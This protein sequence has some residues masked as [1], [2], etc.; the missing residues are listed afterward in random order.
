MSRK[1]I[2]FA[3]TPE[4]ACPSL[5]ALI[6]ANYDIVAVY[7][8]P[9]RPAG[10]QR[11]L[12]PP[13]VKVLA[14]QHGLLVRQPN[15]LR[16]TDTQQDLFA[17]SADV[18]VVAAYGQLL[19]QVV[20]DAPKLGCINVH[21]SL[22][23]RWR[24]AS[25]IQQAILAG[26]TETGITIMQMVLALDAGDGYQQVRCPIHQ[27]DTSASVHDRLAHLG[28]KALCEVIEQLPMAGQAQDESQVTYAHKIKKADAICDWR[29]SA[30]QI[31]REIRAFQPWPVATLD[32]QETRY[33]I[34]KADVCTQTCDAAAGT[35]LAWD[36]NGL[37]IACGDGS[38]RITEI[39]APGKRRQRVADIAPSAVNRF[40]VGTQL[41]LP[42]HP[43]APDTM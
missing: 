14:E 28:T 26:D 23:P 31:E 39:Q 10:R 20:L 17:L 3:G 27:D 7:T 41:T 5:Q 35:I 12:T 38:L 1:R 15:S 40:Q 18:M 4:F 33:R 13:P 2:I 24:G 22:L 42:D 37:H 16:D 6:D 25:P 8:Q 30:I 9:D 29:K 43:T 11:R 34:F 21:A 32:Y 19:P 36:K